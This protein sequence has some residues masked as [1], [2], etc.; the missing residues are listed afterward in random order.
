MPH[1]LVP[2]LTK[3][4][5]TVISPNFLHK[6][7]RW[8]SAQV[9]DVIC[10]VNRASTLLFSNFRHPG[11]LRIRMGHVSVVRCYP[12]QLHA[13][14]QWMSRIN[15]SRSFAHYLDWKL[16]NGLHSLPE[17]I[18]RFLTV[19]CS[20]GTRPTRLKCHCLN[21]FYCSWKVG[22]NS[23]GP[24][25]FSRAQLHAKKFICSNVSSIYCLVFF[26]RVMGMDQI[27]DMTNL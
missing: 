19:C 13:K 14:R 5:K 27:N 20:Q 15:T 10:T 24:L 16:Q 3:Y 23:V 1:S 9:N 8:N 4:S 25:L 22:P 6:H 7:T 18:E 12:I 17:D 2:W 26:S 21:C 11:P